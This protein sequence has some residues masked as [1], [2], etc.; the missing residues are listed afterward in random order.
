V[1]AAVF[2]STLV[3]LMLTPMMCAKLLS[4]SQKRGRLVE[5][6]ER[7][8][9]RAEDSYLRLLHL[10]FRHRLITVLIAIGAFVL[11]VVAL[12]NISQEFAP[13]EDRA[14]F[15]INFETPQGATLAETDAFA[16]EIERI[17]AETPEISHQFLA[18]GLAQAG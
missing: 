18:I 15:G 9:V 8:F 1:V 5:L 10:A 12:A 14:S 4:P 2:A 7:W 11:G 17:L 3:A 6:S 16:R 13:A